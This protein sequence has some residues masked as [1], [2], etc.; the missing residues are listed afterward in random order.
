MSDFKPFSVSI[1]ITN[2]DKTAEVYRSSQV[3]QPPHY[4]GR[5]FA[6]LL[7]S[8]EYKW[9]MIPLLWTV[10]LSVDGLDKRLSVSP[11]PHQSLHI[12]LYPS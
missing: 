6:S 7:H 12:Y 10:A 1:N 11:Q 3:Y 9:C 2:N 5:K 4:C 8:M